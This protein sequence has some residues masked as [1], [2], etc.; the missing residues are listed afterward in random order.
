MSLAADE[1][2][3]EQIE[4]RTLQLQL[5]TTVHLVTKLSQQL[6]ELKDQVMIIVNFFL[7]TYSAYST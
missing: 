4:V 5:E 6:T 1:G 2:E 7:I 3:A